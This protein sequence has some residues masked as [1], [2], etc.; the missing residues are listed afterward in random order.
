MGDKA[1]SKRRMIA[2]GVPCVPGSRGLVPSADEARRLAGEIGYPV[3]LKATAGGGGRG[4]KIV[5]K[6]DEIEMAFKTCS[7]EAEAAF[8]NGGLYIE[9]FVEAPRHV[10]IQLMA[11][12]YNNAVHL[13]E[14]DC[15]VQRRNQKLIEEA[16]SPALSP[17]L[18]AE[19]GQAAV[20]AATAINYRG[21][22]TVEFLLSKSGEFYFMEMNT[23]I[24]VEH[25]VTEYI[26]GVDLIREQIRVAE[27]HKLSFSQE[28]LA[29]NGHSIEAR[30][31]AE[32]PMH[33]FRPMPGLVTGFLPPGG[34]GVRWDGQVFTGWRIPQHVS[35]SIAALSP[36]SIEDTNVLTVCVC[37]CLAYLVL[38]SPL[39]RCPFVTM[40][41]A[42]A[43]CLW[44]CVSTASG[45]DS[46]H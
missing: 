20:N 17:E 25:P 34:N 46:G 42:G 14:R 31:N 5:W 38:F 12:E 3:M 11:D 8:S 21:A 45:C 4:I 36:L 44:M 32:D 24:Q 6:D 40:M 7:A 15:S 43:L 9:K 35:S 16:P 28:D 2:A 23:R 18:R 1:K 39:F 10:E 37:A 30:I 26:T 33:N 22:G 19:M 27:G 41:G 29:F 13:F